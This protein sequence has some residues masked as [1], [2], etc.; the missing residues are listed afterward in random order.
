MLVVLVL[1]LLPL[2]LLLTMLTLLTR[3]TRLTR[4]P[5][6][7]RSSSLTRCRSIVWA[8]SCTRTWRPTVHRTHRGEITTTT[9]AC[10]RRAKVTAPPA[11]R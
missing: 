9:A 1:V 11:S 5:L 8:C 7:T 2:L 10:S 4:L 3:L 6:L